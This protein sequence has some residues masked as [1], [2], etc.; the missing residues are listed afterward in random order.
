MSEATVGATTHRYF[1]CRVH[2]LFIPWSYDGNSLAN[3]IELFFFGLLMYLKLLLMF[4]QQLSCYRCIIFTPLNVSCL[5][6]ICI[7]HLCATFN[8][9]TVSTTGITTGIE[10]VSM[11]FDYICFVG[12]VNFQLDE[13]HW[14]KNYTLCHAFEM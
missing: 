2:F 10:K 4:Y 5:H 12:G 11:H 6:H 9:Y 14:T 13:N 1:L 8:F 7:V 3:K